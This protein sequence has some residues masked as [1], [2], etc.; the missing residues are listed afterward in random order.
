M[1][2][3]EIMRQITTEEKALLILSR[4]GISKLLSAIK[5]HNESIEIKKLLEDLVI[6]LVKSGHK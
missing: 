5:L 3:Y 2:I 4:Y 6:K 1:I